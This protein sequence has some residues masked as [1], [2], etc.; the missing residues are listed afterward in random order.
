MELGPLLQHLGARFKNDPRLRLSIDLSGP[1][2]ALA[3]PTDLQRVLAN[4]V[5]NAARYGRRSQGE[6]AEVVVRG[7]ARSDGVEISVSDRGPGV[8]PAQ[9][10]QLTQPFFRG[11]AARTEASGAGLG[12]AIVEKAVHR[13]KGELAFRNLSP[14]GLEVSIVLPRASD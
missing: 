2:V 12:L 8:P 6:P 9:L 13:M 1:A 10:G 3:D 4:L 11:N 5:E 7:R 14:Q